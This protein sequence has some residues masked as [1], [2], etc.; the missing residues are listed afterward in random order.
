MSS[1]PVYK[2][3]E[4]KSNTIFDYLLKVDKMESHLKKKKFF[5]K[6]KK[7]P[8]INQTKPTFRMGCK[9]NPLKKTK[10]RESIVC[11]AVREGDLLYDA[12]LYL[13]IKISWEMKTKMQL[14]YSAVRECFYICDWH[15]VFSIY[16]HRKYNNFFYIFL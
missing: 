11:N 13:I 2:N 15:L 6:K 9:C 4:G 14:G 1:R 12:H 3:T 8:Q 5:K 10:K 7:S 16:V